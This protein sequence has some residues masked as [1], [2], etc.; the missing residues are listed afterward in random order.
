MHR[1]NAVGLAVSMAPIQN[2]PSAGF[3]RLGGLH[4]E[5]LVKPCLTRKVSVN[6]G[7]FSDM[8]RKSY[9]RRQEGRWGEVQLGVFLETWFLCSGRFQPE[10]T[11]K[12]Y[13]LQTTKEL[14]PSPF[15]S[16]LPN[17]GIHLLLLSP[18]PLPWGSP[19]GQSSLL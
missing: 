13:C 12:F 5:G 3:L 4:V 18:P 6:T 19:Q 17:L 16:F 10:R 14:L 15:T 7:T 9:H 1:K 8:L 11:A 2:H